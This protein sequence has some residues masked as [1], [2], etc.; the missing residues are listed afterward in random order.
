MK[1]KIE[2]RRRVG[3]M[4]QLKPRSHL[5][6]LRRRSPPAWEKLIVVS[7]TLPLASAGR[8]AW[9]ADECIAVCGIRAVVLMGTKRSSPPK[10]K[11]PP[12]RQRKLLP[13]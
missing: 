7:L 3:W 9:P 11:L 5:S 4:S 2:K 13:Q 12:P 10:L 6:R 8:L 1:T